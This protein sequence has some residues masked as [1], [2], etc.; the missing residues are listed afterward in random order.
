MFYQETL[1]LG[2]AKRYAKEGSENG[3]SLHNGPGGEPGRG[4]FSGNSMRQM[5]EGSGNGA[6]LPMGAL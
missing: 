2:D 5:K 4:L 3:I 1:F 6:S